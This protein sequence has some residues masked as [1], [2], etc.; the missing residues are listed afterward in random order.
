MKK[1]KKYKTKTQIAKEK[2]KRQTRKTKAKAKRLHKEIKKALY[3][4]LLAAFGF[5]IAL[6]WR[7]VIQ[8]WVN[9]IAQNSPVQGQ[10]ISALLVTL[11][12]VIGILIV[13]RVFSE[14]KKE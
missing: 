9:K 8:E 6:V 7:D 14:T 10:L 1:S 12:C 11:I 3:T 2:V 13:T 5:L 4:A